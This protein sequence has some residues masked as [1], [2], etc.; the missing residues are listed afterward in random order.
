MSCNLLS[1][2]TSWALHLVFSA[3]EYTLACGHTRTHT[4]RQEV[5]SCQG[6]TQEQLPAAGSPAPVLTR[7][8]PAPAGR[9]QE[10]WSQKSVS[11]HP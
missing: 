5:C 3:R 8:A 1:I 6:I 2:V 7:A 11:P 9:E 10:A 4:T